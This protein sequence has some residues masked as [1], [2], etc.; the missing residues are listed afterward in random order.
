MHPGFVAETGARRLADVERYLRG[1]GAAARAAARRARRRTATAC[2]ASTSSRRLGGS[3]VAAARAGPRE[4]RWMLEELRVSHFAQAL[5]VRGA[6]SAKKI[7][8]LLQG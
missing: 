1:R 3:R 6:V 8:Q 5:G 2:A 4:A 7:R